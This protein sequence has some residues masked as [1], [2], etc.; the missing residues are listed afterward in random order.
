MEHLTCNIPPREQTHLQVRESIREAVRKETRGRK[1]KYP[2]DNPKERKRAAMAEYC[3]NHPEY[4]KIQNEIA[5]QKREAEKLLGI[6]RK[7][8]TDMLKNLPDIKPVK[9][10]IEN[11][12]VMSSQLP[13]EIISRN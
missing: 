3:R 4:R 10:T 1:C 9:I 2:F 12:S 5:K 7:Y 11:L 8:T 6:E 13:S